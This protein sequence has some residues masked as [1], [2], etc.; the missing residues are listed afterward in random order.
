MNKITR[1][2]GLAGTLTMLNLGA[3]YAADVVAPMEEI[4]VPEVFS[5]TG[6]YVGKT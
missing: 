2:A 1:L 5:W 4:V 6:G 3:A